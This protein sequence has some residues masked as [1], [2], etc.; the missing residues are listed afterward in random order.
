VLVLVV[1]L[2]HADSAQGA[3]PEPP[4][5]ECGPHAWLVGSHC[6]CSG[7]CQGKGCQ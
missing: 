1:F 6:A 2:E 5:G 4:P 3:S 7:D